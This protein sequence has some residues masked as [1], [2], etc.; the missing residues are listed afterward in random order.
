MNET[1]VQEVIARLERIETTLASI[2]EKESK[3]DYYDTA[4]IAE[5][6]GKSEFTVREWCRLGRWKAAKKRSGRGKYCSWVISHE[7]LIRYRQ[8]GLLPVP[9]TS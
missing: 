5:L 4:E 1:A 2:V 8:E 9:G 7:E 3:K 6:L